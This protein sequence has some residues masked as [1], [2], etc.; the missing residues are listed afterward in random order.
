MV[1]DN[2]ILLMTNAFELYI[3]YSFLKHIWG[4]VYVDKRL[5]VAVYGI[6]Y[7]VTSVVMIY[8]SYPVVSL[9]TNFLTALM[10]MFCYKTSISKKITVS[11]VL[12]LLLFVSE[13][14]VAAVVGLTDFSTSKK[15]MEDMGNSVSVMDVIMFGVLVIIVK[16]FVKV[17]ADTK[18]PGLF[19]VSMVLVSVSSVVLLSVVFHQSD[20]NSAF[21]VTSLVCVLVSG[22]TIIYLYDSLERLI[23]ERTGRELMKKENVYYK[24]EAALLR[25]NDDDLRKFRHDISNKL[26]VIRNY[27]DNNDTK[28]LNSYLDE[29]TGKLIR[30]RSY[31]N[32]GNLTLD[33]V[34]DYYLTKAENIGAKI[35]ADIVVT[36]RI[37]IEEDDIVIMLGNLLD[38]AVE[39][40]D[41]LKVN[42]YVNLVLHL[43]EGRMLLEIKNNY[44]HKIRKKQGRIVTTKTDEKL[45]GIGLRSVKCVVDKYNGIMDINHKDG[46]FTVTI[47]IG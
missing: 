33:S 29:I 15:A 20:I 14:M 19:T 13:A 6:R 38:N 45:H 34:I 28:K 44:A 18:A 26:M 47:A 3:I 4:Q 37:D 8:V 10:L 35:S 31:S 9:I 36:K 32:S 25:K 17:S 41:N 2:I 40:V 11:I 7:L 30:T 21:V 27:A 16:R 42:S 12:M 23:D 39:A 43:Q 24:N 22:F 5:G 1:F 46:K